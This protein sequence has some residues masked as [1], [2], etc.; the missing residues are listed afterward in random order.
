MESILKKWALL[1]HVIFCMSCGSS[2]KEVTP[3]GNEEEIASISITPQFE[4][5]FVGHETKITAEV[6]GVSGNELGKS[7]NWSV[8]GSGRITKSVGTET[9]LKAIEEGTIEVTA[10][11]NGVSSKIAFK[12]GSRPDFTY[13]HLIQSRLSNPK[14]VFTWLVLIYEK[15]DISANSSRNHPKIEA[16]M[17]K[18]DINGLVDMMR[19]FE[20]FTAQYTGGEIGYN[21]AVVV[22]DERFPLTDFYWSDQNRK[23]EWIEQD[24]IQREINTYTDKGWFDNIHVF[25]PGMGR[26]GPSAAYGGGSYIRDNVTR[27]QYHL[28]GA[29]RNDWYVGTWHEA[30]HGLEVQYWFDSRRNGSTT[31]GIAPNGSAIELHGQPAFGY[32]GNDDNGGARTQNYFHWMADLTTG[33]I[34]DL[35]SAGWQNYD[36]ATNT[37]LGFGSNGMYNYGPVRNEFEFTPGGPFPQRR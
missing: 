26:W 9:N 8:T 28:H 34:R 21:F 22:L 2:D 30:I 20:R 11:L 13:D 6:I 19:G 15:V 18:S 32:Q 3:N 33:N 24:D 10:E 7:V 23:Y 37:G 25:Y 5:L 4:E 16:S 1:I 36:N 35:N 27:S 12:V 14:I 31:R 29:S 17:A